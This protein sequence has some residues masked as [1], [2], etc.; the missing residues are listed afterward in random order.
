MW[1]DVLTKP[2]MGIK[3]RWIRAKL[4]NFPVN[5]NDEAEQLAT[6]RGL[7]PPNENNGPPQGTRGCVQKEGAT[8]IKKTGVTKPLKA[9]ET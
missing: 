3:W 1:S 8:T 6:H 4:M 7:L 9:L 2:L 5:Y